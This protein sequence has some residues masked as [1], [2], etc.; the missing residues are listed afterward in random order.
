MSKMVMLNTISHS[1]I[2]TTSESLKK[3]LQ[4]YINLP[5]MANAS[6]ENALSQHDEK[7]VSNKV[8]F[9]V[10]NKT[11]NNIYGKSPDLKNI[12]FG[13]VSDSL[14]S[15]DRDPDSPEKESLTISDTANHHVVTSYDGLTE[16][17]KVIMTLPNYNI[18]ER[19]WFKHVNEKRTGAWSS[20]F[21]DLNAVRKLGISY[22]SPAFN[23]NNEFI[24]VISSSLYLSDLNKKLVD[25]MRYKNSTLL[26]L[27]S[28]KRI[29][30]S[31][32]SN[33]TKIQNESTSYLLP[34]KM[35]SHK[36][37]SAYNFLLNTSLSHVIKVKIDGS[38]YYLS[39]F[40]VSD[41]NKKFSMQ[42]IIIVPTNA[43]LA[44]I[45]NSNTLFSIVL[46]ILLMSTLLIMLL[47]LHRITTP[48][49]KMAKRMYD[50]NFDIPEP[51]TQRWKFSEIEY[52]EN[53]FRELST[54]LQHSLQALRTEIEID[55]STGLHTMRGLKNNQAIYARRNTIAHIHLSNTKSIM[56][57]LGQKY[58]EDML[59]KFIF[60]LKQLLPTDIILARQNQDK[61]VIVFPGL[62]DMDAIQKFS[63]MILSVLSANKMTVNDIDHPFYGNVG[64]VS[65]L[66]TKEN[67]DMLLTKSWLAL[68]ASE[69]EGSNQVALYSEVMLENEL[70]NIKIKDS[71]RNAIAK[72][73]LHLVLQPI[74]EKRDIVKCVAG[75]CLLRWNSQDLGFVSP[76]QFI[77]VAEES[78][79]IISLGAWVI[80]EACRELSGLISRGAP[81]DFKLHINVSPTQLLSQGFAFHLLDTIAINGLD[82]I[83]ICIEITES[84]L[85]K[86][87]SKV[88]S[89]LNYL[90]RH[91]I[92][93][94]LDDFGTGFSSLSYLQSLPFDDIKIDRSFLKDGLTNPTNLS[95]VKLMISLAKELNVSI[96]AEGIETEAVS[97]TLH[98]M[99]CIRYQGYY[100]ARPDDFSSWH[101]ADNIFYVNES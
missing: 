33:L 7:I 18:K 65:E 12:Q 88:I 94:S 25:L 5:I 71:L 10:L 59:A 38:E 4:D 68:Q 21:M 60:V 85:V 58:T 3:S 53:G 90:R 9:D 23:S 36:I 73:E 96:I 44:T 87:T 1:N 78:G 74:V 84:V 51:Y 50:F 100:F 39:R 46:F 92:S 75:E 41:A 64:F 79:L 13:S 35:A 77:P 42:A 26:I 98:S 17:S 61:L 66:I 83:N 48:L 70:L 62:N 52:L 11:L 15:I 81:K 49:R 16:Q 20:V 14:I 97:E 2:K 22:D 72:K 56:N 91:K 47:I 32:D 55:E 54:K 69:S 45:K 86:E 28:E 31:S 57:V 19:P 43:V 30:A 29:L 93:I 27:D 6:V 80:E 24:G 82:N 8:V 34:I 101:C 67:I 63:T 37:V 76:A 99:G 95:L 89:I 40:P